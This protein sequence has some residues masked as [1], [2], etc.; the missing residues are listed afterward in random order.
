MPIP[1]LLGEWC[2]LQQDSKVITA[3]VGTKTTCLQHLDKIAR[4]SEVS[5]AAGYSS[6][7]S[8]LPLIRTLLL[9]T[10]DPR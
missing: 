7:S 6:F 3:I 8:F 9:C 10:V 4:P 2:P 1:R 5:C